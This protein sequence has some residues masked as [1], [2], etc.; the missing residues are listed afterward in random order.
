M[1]QVPGEIAGN[2]HVKAAVRERQILGVHLTEVYFVRQLARV[3]LRL[4]QHSGGEVDGGHPVARLRE[5]N[6]EEA[7]TRP[8]LQNAN[9]L[10]R[11]LGKSGVNLTAQLGAPIAPAAVGKL[12][13]IGLGITGGALGPV[14]AVSFYDRMVGHNGSS[15]PFI[16]FAL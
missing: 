16:L 3:L 13:L 2:H 6:R 7:G 5:E 12:A 9:V 8:H 11:R 1:G 15:F 4:G 14:A 10:P